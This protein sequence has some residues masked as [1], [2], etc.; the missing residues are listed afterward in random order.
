M[1]L[2]PYLDSETP[3]A[4]AH[5]GGAAEAPE[6]TVEAFQHAVNLG[7]RYLETD[8][9]LSADGIPVAFHDPRIDRV[10]D[11]EGAVEELTWDELSELVIHPRQGGGR[12]A[13]I[14]QLLRDFPDTR[15]NIDAKT[16]AVVDPLLDVIVAADALDRVCVASFFDQRLAK[17]RDRLGDSGCVSQGPFDTVVTLAKGKF[18]AGSNTGSS[19]PLQ[20]P[21]NLGPLPMPFT[22]IVAAA[23]PTGS[24]VHVWTVDDASRM[25]ELLDMGVN[26][27]MTDRPTVL[28]DV[29]IERGQ[30]AAN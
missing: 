6:N 20:L 30:W 2:H 13:S 17:V 8:A 25:H 27:I 22:K 23:R 29:L 21:D 3:I 10:T 9:Q 28:R 12:L 19:R 26:G 15:F 14:E 1:S 11:R 5:R 16:A 7:Y 18:G 4:F 24:P